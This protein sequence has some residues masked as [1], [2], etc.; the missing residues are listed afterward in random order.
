MIL[1]KKMSLAI[2]VGS[3]ALLVL[4]SPA[5]AGGG[6]QLLTVIPLG[7]GQG[8]VTSSPAGIDCGKNDPN[9]S[10]CD[11][12]F[13][14]GSSVTLTAN[15]DPNNDFEGF[16]GENCPQ[17]GKTCT[18]TMSQ[19]R[20]V[21]A[22]FTPTQRTLTLTTAGAGV[23]YVESSEG[24]ID[25][26]RNI[27]TRTDCSESHNHGSILTLKANPAANSEF[28]GFTGGGCSGSGTT[29]SIT[30]DQDRAVTATFAPT[31]R[32]LAVTGAGAGSGYVDSAPSGID[33]GQNLAGHADC[34]QS[35]EHGRTVTLTAVPSSDSDFAG[36]SGGDCSGTSTKCTV[37]MDQAR[38]ITATFTLKPID[39]TP[40]TDTPTN[41]FSWSAIE[42]GAR[43][44]L[45]MR[46]TLPGAGVLDVTPRPARHMTGPVHVEVD[47]E[48]SRKVV[49][50]L[51][52]A[53]RKMLRET[54]DTLAIRITASYTP[55]GGT[56]RVV[57][58][59]VR[60]RAVRRDG[61]WVIVR[62]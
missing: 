35:Y 36:F 58:R 28:V 60:V 48:A 37:I 13:A 17:T 29:C 16:N 4:A 14:S 3:I 1:L 32:A 27:S 2:L 5:M 21:S 18:L 38:S 61:E 41:R 31:Q 25:C 47:G 8:H 15:P 30:M 56:A 51:T 57:R 11:N 50:R 12:S 40:P 24:G 52:R 46:F 49:L 59:T 26:G 6:T 9:H 53:A 42:V 55:E 20:T 54:G 43:G 44:K 62:A 45:T 34:A 19:A 23:G 33:C 22:T 39:P 7:N 10:S